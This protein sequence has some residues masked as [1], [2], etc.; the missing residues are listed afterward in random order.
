[1]RKYLDLLAAA[2]ERGDGD[3]RSRVNNDQR[4]F[5]TDDVMASATSLLVV[6]DMGTRQIP[7][8]RAR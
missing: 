8:T 5:L 7:L 2:C 4:T 6:E 1:M 3:G